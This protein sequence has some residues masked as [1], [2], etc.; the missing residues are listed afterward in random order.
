MGRVWIPP[1][2]GKRLK[3]GKPDEDH[4]SAFDI[5]DGYGDVQ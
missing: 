3:G 2:L 4:I 1:G 5:G